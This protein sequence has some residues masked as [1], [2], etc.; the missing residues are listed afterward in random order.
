[1]LRHRAAMTW[2]AE[3]LIEGFWEGAV[4]VAYRK[5]GWVGGAVALLA[6]F[7]VIGL[8]LWLVL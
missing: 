3:I 2:I 8:V 7:V 4:E 6:P 5:G 1:M